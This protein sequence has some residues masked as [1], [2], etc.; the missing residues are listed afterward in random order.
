MGSD[1]TLLARYSNTKTLHLGAQRMTLW[2]A[3]DVAT[4]LFLSERQCCD[5]D[6]VS[7]EATIVVGQT[8]HTRSTASSSLLFLVVVSQQTSVHL[9]PAP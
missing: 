9:F 7:C 2:G 1:L 8:D 6:L 3:G 5:C 4:G